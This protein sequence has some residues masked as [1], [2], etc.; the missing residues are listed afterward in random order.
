MK[1][2]K[3]AI[4]G[5]A[6]SGKSTV[7]RLVA[8]ALGY[9]YVDTGAMYRAVTLAALR[10]GVPLGDEEAL[11]RLAARINID[12]KPLPDGGQ[13]V[14]LDGEEVTQAI[15]SPE[16]NG[17]VSQVA[18][19]YGVRRVLSRR[20]QE[21]G[22]LG[23]VVM[24]GRDIGTVVLPQAEVKVFLTASLEER[25]RRRLKELRDRGFTLTENEVREE[26]LRRDREDAGRALAPLKPA[27]DAIVLDTSNLTPE[28]ATA[29]IVALVR[30]RAGN[31]V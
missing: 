7:A 1:K 9:L 13:A 25:T 31:S 15:R 20:Q 6:G 23:G 21:L 16:V 30:E 5:P 27:P 3:V 26:V 22:A 2:L 10:A 14:F 12:L 11:G 28:E 17:A 18:K 19:V 29:R 24:D 8:Q 4:D